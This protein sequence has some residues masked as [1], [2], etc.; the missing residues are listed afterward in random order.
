M[1]G[2][3][4]RTKL[5]MNS[6]FKKRIRSKKFLIWVIIMPMLLIGFLNLIG[7]SGGIKANVAVVDKDSSNISN[8]TMSLLRSQDRLDVEEVNTVEQGT[9][10]IKRGKVEALVV[11]PEDFSEKWEKIEEGNRSYEPIRFKVYHAGGEQEKLIDTVLKGIT[12]DINE[13]IEGEGE[14][15]PVELDNR[16]VDIR[17]WTYTDLLL[18]GGILIILLQLGLLASSNHSSTLKEDM[19]YKRLKISPLP[20]VYSISGMVITDALFTAVAGMIALVTGLILF[21]ISVPIYNVFAMALFLVISSL[22]FSYIGC[23]IGWISSKQDSAQGLS[24]M[25]IF[26]LIFFSHGYLFSTIFPDYVVKI[27]KWLPIYPH[28][29]ILKK[30]LFYSPSAMDVIWN[31]GHSLVWLLGVLSI[32][33]LL[34][35][36]S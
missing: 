28:V 16:S 29:D 26:P 10:L 20:Q 8:T 30:L 9:D 19:S 14:N 33:I 2:K 18:P 3:L 7:G 12:A 4:K 34:F 5:F 11:I 35:K 24:S 31:L 23:L 17:D 36:R 25:L 32:A 22:T 21:G 15:E 27:S 1:K 6:Q 13:F